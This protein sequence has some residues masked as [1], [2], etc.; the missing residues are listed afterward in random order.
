MIRGPRPP[1]VRWAQAQNRQPPRG[2][3]L[4]ARRGRW[5]PGP[6]PGRD[7]R[8]ST[9]GS[10]QARS[11]PET[12][13]ANASTRIAKLELAMEAVGESDPTYASL[14]D[15]FEKC[16]CPSSGPASSGSD[17]RDG[18]VRRKCKE[19]CRDR[20]HGSVESQ[21][22]G[23]QGRSQVGFR[24]PGAR[25][26]P[27]RLTALQQEARVTKQS[28]ASNSA[29]RVRPGVGQTPCSRARVDARE[30]RVEV[31]IRRCPW[32]RGPTPEL[33]VPSHSITGF[34]DDS[35]K[36]S[37]GAATQCIKFDGDSDRPRRREYEG[38]RG[39]EFALNCRD[40]RFGLRGI[41]VGDASHPGPHSGCN[42]P[43][44]P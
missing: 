43:R 27:A 3:P 42:G 31:R 12:I 13:M 16:T 39:H 25:R 23:G 32:H 29:S 19:A 34:G 24:G 10:P 8:Q 4:D 37:V 26:R 9:A 14:S 33:E 6:Q 35:T 17:C 40:A 18:V 36:Q 41:R 15:A 5:R 7:R 30:G 44:V 11:D 2:Q 21:S 20:S 38:F 1:S 22:R 28:P